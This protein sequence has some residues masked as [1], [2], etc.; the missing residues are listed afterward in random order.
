MSII[1]QGGI[2]VYDK[3]QGK[4]IDKIQKE[5]AEKEAEKERI[6]EELTK[7]SIDFS[8]VANGGATIVDGNK[9]G[10]TKKEDDDILFS[11]K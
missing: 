11:T 8:E 9:V 1:L 4:F 3:E 7:P 10:N 6:E 2:P 5:Q